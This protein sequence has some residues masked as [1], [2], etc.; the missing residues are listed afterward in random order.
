M[1]RFMMLQKYKG[2]GKIRGVEMGVNYGTYVVE[3]NAHM[4]WLENIK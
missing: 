1:W 4:F 3:T 2:G